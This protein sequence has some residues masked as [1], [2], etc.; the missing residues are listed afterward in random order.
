MAARSVIKSAR[1]FTLIE[2]LIVVAIVGLLA[3]F[4]VLQL[5][6]A[7]SAANESSTIASLRSISS[8]QVLY[9][10]SCGLGGYAV[11]LTILGTSTPGSTVPFL[12]PDLTIATTVQK[13][14]Y[15]LTLTAGAGGAPGPADCNGAPT[16]D[17]Y[18]ASGRPVLYPFNGGRSFAVAAAGVI[19][20]DLAAVPPGEPFSA[21][22]TPIN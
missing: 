2:L 18:Y 4:A 10:G 17:A 19:W 7:R 21:P 16:T 8:S 12:S 15:E 14:G 20:Q 22:A 11:D 6:R 1:G 5:L 3:S 13:S 9:A